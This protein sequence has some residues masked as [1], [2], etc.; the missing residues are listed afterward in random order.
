M[1]IEEVGYARLGWLQER[2]FFKKGMAVDDTIAR[3][4]SVI[5]PD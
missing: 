5:K 2:G 3:I 1:G 4:I